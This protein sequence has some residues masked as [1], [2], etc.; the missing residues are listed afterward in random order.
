MKISC[1]LEEYRRV[2]NGTLIDTYRNFFLKKR[3]QSRFRRLTNSL[4]RRIKRIRYSLR[5]TEE[6][7]RLY[8]MPVIEVFCEHDLGIKAAHQL[9]C[10]DGQNE[11]IIRVNSAMVT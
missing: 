7:S 3:L 9:E 1:T 11:E 5:K 6:S 4:R 8:A 2:F 10:A